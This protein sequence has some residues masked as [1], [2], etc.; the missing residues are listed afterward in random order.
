MRLEGEAAATT[1]REPSR[2]YYA[3]AVSPDPYLTRLIYPSLSPTTHSRPRSPFSDA[4]PFS[5]ALCQS[6]R[7]TAVYTIFRPSHRVTGTSPSLPPFSFARI[8]VPGSPERP[9]ADWMILRRLG[10]RVSSRTI[11]ARGIPRASRIGRSRGGLRRSKE[12][13]DLTRPV[14]THPLR[15]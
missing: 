13:S 10:I 7:A 8:S 6:T 2:P 4:A 14:P 15:S 9:R 12:A 1:R 5:G 11:S 3:T